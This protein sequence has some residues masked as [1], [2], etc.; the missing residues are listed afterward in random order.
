MPFDATLS[1]T[2][3]YLHFVSKLRL[4]CGKKSASTNFVHGSLT[5]LLPLTPTTS[6]SHLNETPLLMRKCQ[7][8]SLMFCF[9]VVF[10]IISGI[11][12]AVSIVV[13]VKLKVLFMHSP[14]W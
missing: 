13:T 9:S 6:A 10:H 8:L 12:N 7:P 5:H 14:F 1:E 4:Q 11:G 3:H 2:T